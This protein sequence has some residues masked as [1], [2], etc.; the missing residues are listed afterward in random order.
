MGIPNLEDMLSF[1]QVQIIQEFLHCHS[2]TD[3]PLTKFIIRLNQRLILTKQIL[4]IICIM[5]FQY[6]FFCR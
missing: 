3:D 1:F 5:T 6:H 2:Y 4:K